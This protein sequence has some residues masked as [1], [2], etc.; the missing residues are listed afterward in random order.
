MSPGGRAL[1]RLAERIAAEGEPL[2]L[3]QKWRGRHPGGSTPG[4]AGDDPRFGDLAAAGPLTAGDPDRH[5][6]V[7][8]AI[9]EGY[10]CHYGGSRLLDL[11]DP[12]LALL[13][14]DL[15]YAI[16]LNDLSGLGD[17]ES[18]GILSDL[19]RIAADLGAGGHPERAAVLWKVQIVALSCGKPDDYQELTGAI[20]GGD[21]APLEELFEWAAATAE[22]AGI[23]P[24][25]R[26]GPERIHL[27]P[28]NL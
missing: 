13:A 20:A 12:D 16:G 23:G 3:R 17:L 6:F 2:V 19:I 24:E 14:G 28:S 8:E 11:P 18:T 27:R 1:A 4:Y 21:P 22:R 25:F 9:R 10:L 5:A 7:V 26:K 15:L